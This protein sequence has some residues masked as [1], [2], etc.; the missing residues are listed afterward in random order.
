MTVYTR[1]T[2]ATPKVTCITHGPS[3]ETLDSMVT[4]PRGILL[5]GQSR[6]IREGHPTVGVLERPY[7]AVPGLTGMGSVQGRTHIPWRAACIMRTSHPTSRLLPPCTT[8]LDH[9]GA[10]VVGLV[11]PGEHL[12][13]RSHSSDSPSRAHVVWAVHLPSPRP[14]E[15]ELDQGEW[16]SPPSSPPSTGAG[17]VFS[18]Q[19]LR[20]ALE[21]YVDLWQTLCPRPAG[22]RCPH[23]MGDCALALPGR[24]LLPPPR[25]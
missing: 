2:P 8:E 22:L 4:S 12:A 13:A 25:W 14:H 19:T 10:S 18:L 7:V 24:D 9:P 3:L 21:H 16:R 5:A 11:E 6:S 1:A 15:A 23:E 17:L 20:G